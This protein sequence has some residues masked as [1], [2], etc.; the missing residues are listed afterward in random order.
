MT[1]SSSVWACRH[2]LSFRA[3]IALNESDSRFA[4]SKDDECTSALS[5]FDLGLLAAFCNEEISWNWLCQLQ[6]LKL[7]K[8]SLDCLKHVSKISSEKSGANR[9][10]ERFVTHQA[11]DTS[12]MR[13]SP[14]PN[15][16]IREGL[17][18]PFEWNDKERL[19]SVDLDNER[20]STLVL[21]SGVSITLLDAHAAERTSDRRVRC[22]R[23]PKEG[24]ILRRANFC[25]SLPRLGVVD[26]IDQGIS[27]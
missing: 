19:G 21:I 25:R 22:C 10:R 14:R 24:Q 4:V 12:A 20:H 8:H 13:E 6:Y 27:I 16:Y 26:S 9:K 7:S 5:T 1:A 17:A 2:N 15:V 18:E 3:E 23:M 11:P